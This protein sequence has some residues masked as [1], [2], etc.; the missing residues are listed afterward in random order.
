MIATPSVPIES[1][2]SEPLA[3]NNTP[4]DDAVWPGSSSVW[5]GTSGDCAFVIVVGIGTKTTLELLMSITIDLGVFAV[6]CAVLSC[7][8]AL[9][10]TESALSEPLVLGSAIAVLSSKAV[11]GSAEDAI[12]S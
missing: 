4:A 7:D 5:V 3:E 1:T 12:G 9:S 6:G 11:F 10:R 8:N 2:A